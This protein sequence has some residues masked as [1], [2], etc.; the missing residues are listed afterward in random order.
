MRDRDE[1][2]ARLSRFEKQF[3]PRFEKSYRRLVEDG[4]V[5]VLDAERG[6][7]DPEP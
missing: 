2:L 3:F 6:S 4:K 7:F 5:L 1:L